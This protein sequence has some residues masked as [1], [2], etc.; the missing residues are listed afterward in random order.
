MKIVDQL[1]DDGAKTVQEINP[2]ITECKSKRIT[3]TLLS[4]GGFH[5]EILKFFYPEYML[6]MILSN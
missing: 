1:I 2:D 3:T 6:K 5:A 4:I